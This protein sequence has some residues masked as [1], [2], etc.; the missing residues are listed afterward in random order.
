MPSV[1]CAML[2]EDDEVKQKRKEDARAESRRRGQRVSMT[3]DHKLEARAHVAKERTAAAAML[4]NSNL[5]SKDDGRR[6]HQAVVDFQK[7]RWG[8][9]NSVWGIGFQKHIEFHRSCIPADADLLT[10]KNVYNQEGHITGGGLPFS[11]RL[12]GDDILFMPRYVLSCG[13]YL[14]LLLLRLLVLT[15]FYFSH[16]FSP[17]FT[18]S[19]RKDPSRS[20]LARHGVQPCLEFCPVSHRGS[21][22]KC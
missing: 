2:R 4:Y 7:P 13:W 1:A 10:V 18:H 21:W 11:L 15:A 22:L 3:E 12:D 9:V 8:L 20:S 14:L 19:T 6:S 16:F 17:P 5:Q